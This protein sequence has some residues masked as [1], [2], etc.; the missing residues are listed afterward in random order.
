MT[1]AR[2]RSVG[3]DGLLVLEN[4]KKAD[5]TMRIF[6]PDGGEVDM[7]GNGSRCM[8]YYA[9]KKG[10][11]KNNS[12]S[13]ETKAGI[14][15]AEVEGEAARIEMT[16]PGSLKTKFSLKLGGRTIEA[17]FVNTG[18]PHVVSVVEDLEGVN[19]KKLGREIR[20]HKQFAPE[21]TNAN[22]VKVKNKNTIS[23]RTYERGV[24]DETLACGTGAVA[25]SIVTAELGYAEAP[26]KVKTW[27]GDAMYIY[28]K[29]I[30]G[31]YK[32]VFL[33]GEVKLVC[34]GRMDYV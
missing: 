32:D 33:E 14:L 22:F 27:G 15:K 30:G 18:V 4:S 31:E 6:N 24:E 2:K 16:K 12:L 25:S 5:I 26:V 19:V 3:A 9:A 10:L 17:G 29:K 21:G 20:N 28:F 13:I 1:C 34:E 23:I 11:A 7:C 8:A